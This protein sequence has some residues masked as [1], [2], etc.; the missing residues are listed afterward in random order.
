MNK[1]K[2]AILII[3]QWETPWG[4]KKGVGVP[5]RHR[6][7]KKWASKGY[8]VY[9]VSGTSKKGMSDREEDCYTQFYFK[10]PLFQWDLKNLPVKP[11]STINFIIRKMFSIWDITV[12]TIF[13]TI[14]TFKV[15]KS[16]DV[17]LIYSFGEFGVLV[18]KLIARLRGVPFVVRLYGT[19]LYSSFKAVGSLSWKRFLYVPLINYLA[20]RINAEQIIVT[21]DDCKADLLPQFMKIR[22]PMALIRIGVDKLPFL[23]VKVNNIDLIKKQYGLDKYHVV[24][25]N[26]GRFA[27]RKRNHLLLKALPKVISAIKDVKIGVALIGGGESLKKYQNIIQQHGLQPYVKICGP[28]PR[29]EIPTFFYC[30]D[31]YYSVLSQM[32]LCTAFVEAMVTGRCV[33]TTDELRENEFVINNKTVVMVQEADNEEEMVNSIAEKIIFLVRNKNFRNLI[34][35]NAKLY[36]E[37]FVPTVDEAVE[38][39]FEI[40]KN[41]IK[42]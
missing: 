32:N 31:I 39:E 37:R 35:R 25:G 41:L 15:T 2:R 34:A 8:D 14:K 13:A 17:A 5:E 18:S 1:N 42:N 16:R 23:N 9:V 6:L 33:L 20:F 7:I 38:K 10:L 22:A 4:V 26:I 30:I 11:K 24:V 19:I 12:F 28:V 36:A 3:S 40:A 21:D 27:E 29:E